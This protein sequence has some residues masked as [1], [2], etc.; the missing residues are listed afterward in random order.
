MWNTCHIQSTLANR[1]HSSDWHSIQCWSLHT[2]K[3]FTFDRTW[4]RGVPTNTQIYK[5]DDRGNSAW[6][7]WVLLNTTNPWD[8]SEK[9]LTCLI[10]EP[11]IVFVAFP[12][13]WWSNSWLAAKLRTPL[14]EA[15]RRQN[16]IFTQ[17]M[18]FWDQML[19]TEVELRSWLWEKPPR[20]NS[21]FPLK[22]SQVR[23]MKLLWFL[24]EDTQ[25]TQFHRSAV[26]VKLLKYLCHC[27]L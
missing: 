4:D 17:P 26:A 22:D 10:N 23:K 20:V 11:V 15:G 12:V 5:A 14:Q 3:I 6:W 25:G 19:N 7:V 1:K 9:P 8:M 24:T 27:Y 2:A 16:C 13:E 18:P 21:Q